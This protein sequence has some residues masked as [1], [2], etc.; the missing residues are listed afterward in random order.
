METQKGEQRQAAKPPRE[1]ALSVYSMNGPH[2]QPRQA[3]QPCDAG[4]QS[5]GLW[6]I[7]CFLC[8]FRAALV[9]ELFSPEFTAQRAYVL[10]HTVASACNRACGSL[11]S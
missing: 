6:L 5:S 8:I 7:P 1:L 4:L 10:Q 2:M 11:L 3:P 9:P